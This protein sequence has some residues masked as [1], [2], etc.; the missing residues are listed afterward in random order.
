MTCL[1]HLGHDIWSCWRE[2]SAAVVARHTSLTRGIDTRR[3]RRGRPQKPLWC[4]GIV[5]HVAGAA[6][7]ESHCAVETDICRGGRLIRR[8]RMNAAR[9][10]GKRIWLPRHHPVWIVAGQTKLTARTIAYQKLLP[11]LINPL[12][13]GAVTTGA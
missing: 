6:S 4:C 5:I 9:P 13:M 2:Q 8:S 7:I 1:R 11:D 3:R 10:A 12:H